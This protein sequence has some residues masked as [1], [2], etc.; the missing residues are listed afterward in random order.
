MMKKKYRF[1]RMYVSGLQP[2]Y[3]ECHGTIP[4]L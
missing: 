1:Y 4:L 2:E 3:K